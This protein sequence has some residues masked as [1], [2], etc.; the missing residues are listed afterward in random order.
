[1]I[2]NLKALG[3]AVLAVCALGA[4]SASSASAFFTSSVEHVSVSGSQTTNHVFTTSV[5]TVTCK[6][7]TFAGTSIGTAKEG[8]FTTESQ[9]VTPTYGECTAFGFGATVTTTGCTYKFTRTGT[10][11]TGT[12]IGPVHVECEAGKKIKIVAAGFCTMEVG[13]QTPEGHVSFK[14]TFPPGNGLTVEDVDVKST[15]TG[16][17]YE[18]NCGSGTNGTYSGEATVRGFNTAGEPVNVTVM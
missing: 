2:R 6:K 15:V 4:V 14:T 1:M 5:G 10:D 12:P 3:L 11:G 7:A 17:K 16:I 13:P 9:T 8:Q 18:G